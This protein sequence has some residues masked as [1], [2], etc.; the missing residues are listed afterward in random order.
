MNKVSLTKLFFTLALALI[1]FA[2]YMTFIYAPDEQI[3]GAV[4]R[5][6]YFHVGAAIASYCSFLMIFIGCIGYL[7]TRNSNYD[8]I[9]MASAE[10]GFLLCTIVLGSGM[11]WAHSAWGV[12]FNTEPRLISFLL[13]WFGLIAYLIFRNFGDQLK[14]AIHSAVLG[15]LICVTVPVM[16]LSIKYLPAFKQLHPIVIERGG[17][18][19]A[20]R[21]SLI[22][23]IFAL[24]AF[25]FLLVIIRYRL[26]LI[27]NQ[28]IKNRE[29]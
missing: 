3:M 13:I 28:I 22:V 26:A 1:P 11:I 21:T 20:M 29:S 4:Q 5:I 17:L 18:D 2:L 24:I 10:V 7:A 27:E 6:F 8:L 25:Q 16:V 23:A 14:Q 19:P 15:I 9:A 12:W